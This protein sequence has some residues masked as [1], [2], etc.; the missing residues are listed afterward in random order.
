MRD[1]F[2]PRE[3]Q[4]M[5]LKVYLAGRITRQEEVRTI[6]TQLRE[7]GLEVTRDW[8]WT[9]AITN[10]QEAGAFRKRDYT[11]LNPKYHTE[12]DECLNAVLEADVFIILSD[13]NGSGMYVEMGA[14][15]AA[16][17]IRNKPR[18]LYAI[19]PHFDRM[20]FYQHQ[21]IQRVKSVEE[22]LGDLRKRSLL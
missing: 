20:L 12:A 10:E 9:T 16:H 21:T 11:E 5:S 14:A 4:C 15:F 1:R 17:K 13:E 7:A 6:L 3:K 22:V 2:Y 18:L 8:T 19:G